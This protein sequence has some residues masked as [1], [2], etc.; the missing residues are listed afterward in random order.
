VLVC[1][2]WPV[3]AFAGEL[4]VIHGYARA[5]PPG[6]NSAAAYLILNNDA[7]KNVVLIGVTSKAAKQVMI[8]QNQLQGDMMRM[9]RV[10]QLELAAGSQFR[11]EPG[12][13]HLM[14]TGLAKP[15]RA[16]EQLQL[17]LHFQQGY[18]LEVNV[19]VLASD[20]VMGMKN[21]HE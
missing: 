12:G 9:R 15:L 4:A 21:H 14:L 6:V 10:S 20:A 5:T 1:F 3:S 19:P 2:L 16:G 17:S 7:E 13:Y 11:F 18:V 8:H